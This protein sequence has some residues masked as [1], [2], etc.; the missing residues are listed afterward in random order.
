MA[1][2]E[3]SSDK[4]PNFSDS[5]QEILTKKKNFKTSKKNSVIKKDLSSSEEEVHE[6]KKKVSYNKKKDLQL[7]SFKYDIS[8]QDHTFRALDK[9]TGSIEVDLI[10]TKGFDKN[11]V[12]IFYLST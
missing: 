8:D 12:I 11:D 7:I 4:K 6:P 9:K 1:V 2:A 3:E 5:E 10:T